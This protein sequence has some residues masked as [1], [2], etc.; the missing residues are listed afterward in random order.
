MPGWTSWGNELDGSY[1]VS[2]LAYAL[3]SR[4][5]SLNVKPPLLRM[6]GDDSEA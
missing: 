3:T 5:S 1:Q 4:I 6:M 2:W